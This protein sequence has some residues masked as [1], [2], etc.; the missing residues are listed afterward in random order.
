MV[1]SKDEPMYLPD[2]TTRVDNS[3][4]RYQ[5]KQPGSLFGPTVGLMSCFVCGVHRSRAY[6]RPFKVAAATHY[7]C[8][9]GCGQ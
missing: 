5:S 6:L 7:R 2:Q 3:G 4:L 1:F 8:R 9:A